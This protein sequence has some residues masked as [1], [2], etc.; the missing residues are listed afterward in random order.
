MLTS[1][2]C[3]TDWLEHVLS[4]YDILARV[5]LSCTIECNLVKNI[6]IVRWWNIFVSSNLVRAIHWLDKTRVVRDC[7]VRYDVYSNSFF[8]KCLAYLKC[9][10]VYI[11]V[12]EV[13]LD[14]TEQNEQYLIGQLLWSIFPFWFEDPIA[15]IWIRVSNS[16]PSFLCIYSWQREQFI[17]RQTQRE[18]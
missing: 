4:T 16:I 8:S 9:I 10:C 1:L 7:T 17:Y 5:D 15:S 18:R 3:V 6:R 13:K 12:H 2:E 11:R 14:R